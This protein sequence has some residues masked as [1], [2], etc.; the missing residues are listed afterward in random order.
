MAARRQVE[1]GGVRRR[2]GHLQHTDTTN[3][4]GSCV[5]AASGHNAAAPP[6]SVIGLASYRLCQRETSL[7][8]RQVFMAGPDLPPA[9]L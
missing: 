1:V 6:S 3:L 5:R 2:R 7:E 9:G 8:M 4:P